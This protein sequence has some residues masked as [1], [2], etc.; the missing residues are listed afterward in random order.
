MSTVTKIA[1][2][3]LD[4]TLVDPAEAITGGMA[5]AIEAHGFPRPSD[6]T[7]RKFVGPPSSFCLTHYTDI[8]QEQHLAVLATYRAGYQEHGI[9]Q[10]RVYP[11]IVETLQKLQNSGVKIGLATQKP[12][13]LAQKVL[14]YFELTPY[15]D[16]ISGAPD[17]L[18]TGDQTLPKDKPGII[19]RAL[20]DLEI[21]N[22]EFAAVMIGDRIFD[23]EGARANSITSV[24]VTW[25]FAPDGELEAEFDEVVSNPQELQATLSRL[26]EVTL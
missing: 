4:G 20:S 7:M 11:G 6:E 15:F 17:D 12:L 1:L 3:D 9:A 19:A 2:W 16:V 8:P 10:S 25:G 24:G 18:G 14:D 22:S 23:A 5:D 21:Q 13:F 26:L